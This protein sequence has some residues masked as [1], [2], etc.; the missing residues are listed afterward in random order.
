MKL[1]LMAHDLVGGQIANWLIENY[2]D[3]VH[4]VVVKENSPIKEL[5]EGKVPW[6][7]QEWI[8]YSTYTLDFDLGLLAW[9]PD[10]IK[11]DLLTLPKYGWVNTHPSLLPCCRGKH[12]NFWAIV[13]ELPYGV[14]LH[15]VEETTDSG[16]IIAQKEIPYTWEDTGE[17]LFLEAR[18]A[19]FDLFKET[20]PIIREL[21]FK[22]TLQKERGSSFHHSRELE[23]K[24]QIFLKTEYTGRELLN[25]LRART[26]TGHPSC[27]FEEDGEKYEVRVN[28]RRQK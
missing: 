22:T 21:N 12:P 2:R 16:P 25:L 24:S 23:K 19:I 18:T 1:L 9:W 5:C 15:A 7:T 3:D 8:D 14:T 28:I 6:T 27:W 4:L 11:G 26:F 13:D 10:L 20:Y 17:S